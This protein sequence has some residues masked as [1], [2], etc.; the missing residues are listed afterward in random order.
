MGA[1]GFLL[2]CALAFFAIRMLVRPMKPVYRA[3]VWLLV[4]GFA[5]SLPFCYLLFPSYRQFLALCERP[6]RQ[7]IQKT[8]EVAH[9]YVGGGSFAAHALSE[10][11]GFQSFEIKR[12]RGQPGY[13]RFTHGDDWATPACRSGC[14]SPQLLEWEA[15][16]ESNC[17][18]KTVI[19]APTWEYGFA[20]ATVTL[21]E[22]RLIR[23][24]DT[25]LSPSG[26]V[27]ASAVNY[28]YHPYGNGWAKVLG[29]A[30]GSAPS[31][32]CAGK[33]GVWG[34]EFLRPTLRQ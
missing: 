15:R 23:T 25:A 10:R 12:D 14:A 30:S 33:A 4:L 22:G 19:A 3:C 20:Q 29:L 27:L 32:A 24:S 34:L 9:L 16:C 2:A 21:V 26:E 31:M 8:V 5:V 18:T 1:I 13:F 6:D 11:L 7:V 17:Y 28:L